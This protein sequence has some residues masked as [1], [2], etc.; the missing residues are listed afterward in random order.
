MHLHGF[1]ENSFLQFYKEKKLKTEIN[2]V[3]IYIYYDTYCENAT[4]K[5]CGSVWKRF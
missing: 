1:T 5:L 3:K 4:E 2:V